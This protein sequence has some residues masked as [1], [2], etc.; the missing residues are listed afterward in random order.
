MPNQNW[1]SLSS[2]Q[3]GRYA[4]YY[5]KME[6]ASY[7]FEVYTSEVDD[8]GID[9]VAK[10]SEKS[11]FFEFQVKS[12]RRMNYVYLPKKTWHIDN[13]YL[14]LILV[15]FV[16]GAA[17]NIYLIPA[18]AWKEPTDLL[19][20]HSY[21]GEHYKSAPEYCVNIAL[22]NMRLLEPY[23]FDININKLKD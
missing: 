19:R 17:P 1:E 7:G 5:A 15:V 20:Y 21:D 3:I 16:E 6:V 14:Y 10:Y 11:R 2:L 9:F 12:I 13:E 4:E 18:S 23:R 22:K 8:H